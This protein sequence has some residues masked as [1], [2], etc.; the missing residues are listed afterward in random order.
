MNKYK[1]I[2]DNF[3]STDSYTKNAIVQTNVREN[4]ITKCLDNLKM[5]NIKNILNIGVRDIS[6]PIELQNRFLAKQI[7]VIDLTLENISEQTKNKNITFHE[8]NFDKDLDKL[9]QK[10][11]LIFSNMSLQWSKDLNKLLET[12]NKKLNEQSM[13]AFSTLLEKNF[14]ELSGIFRI[15]KML[16]K[17]SILNLMKK[18]GLIC[19]YEESYFYKLDFNSFSDL[20]N[21]FKSTGIT[22]Y[23]G[24]NSSSKAFSVR[25]LIK[26]KSIYSLTYHVGIFICYKN[27]EFK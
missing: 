13:F 26:N 17:E 8:L 9:P 18:N 10:Y 6:E 4:L 16:T 2:K 11:D 3:S 25:S 14:H 24:K 1:N 7:D 23:T 19:L 5:R 21:H 27:K 22:T 12:L 20:R 15:N